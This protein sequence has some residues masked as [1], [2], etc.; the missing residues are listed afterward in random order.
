MK[1]RVSKWERSLKDEFD[2][3][4][5]RN[6]SP[7]AAE[8]FARLI[9]ELRDQGAGKGLNIGDKAPEFTLGC[10]GQTRFII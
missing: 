2:A 3:L 6:M 7:D 4:Q 10:Y 8:T 1:N 5:A 9:Q